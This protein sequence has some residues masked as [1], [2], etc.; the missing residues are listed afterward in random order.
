MKR[1]SALCV[2]VLSVAVLLAIAFATGNAQTADKT[3]E[4]T[5]YQRLGGAYAIATV[6]DDFIE[7]LLVNDVLNANPA[8]KEARDRVPKAGLKFHVTAMVC[9]ATGG[10]EQYAG[11]SMKETHK[12]LNIS[13]KEWQAMAADFKITLDKFK[14]PQKEQ[15]ELFAIVGTTKADIVMAGK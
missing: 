8:I 6:V 14:V 5:L 2:V 9:Q 1:N 7:R 11:R 15:D 12:H 13:E 10:P 4:P 3:A